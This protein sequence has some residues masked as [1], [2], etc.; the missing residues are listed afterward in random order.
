MSIISFFDILS[1]D[2]HR[3]I[4]NLILEIQ[5]QKLKKSYCSLIM[6]N[7]DCFNAILFESVFCKQLPYIWG[8]L[9]VSTKP[10]LCDRIRVN[11]CISGYLDKYDL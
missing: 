5:K 11:K 7:D 9:I 2:I 6:F 8:T 4:A 3:I 1:L 10:I